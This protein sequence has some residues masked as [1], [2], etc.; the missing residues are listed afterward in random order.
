MEAGRRRG[1]RGH[2]AREGLGGQLSPNRVSR[3]RRLAAG[4]AMLRLGASNAGARL[5]QDL[6][7]QQRPSGPNDAATGE[8]EA[9]PPLPAIDVVKQEVCR[10]LADGYRLCL[11]PSPTPRLPGGLIPFEGSTGPLPYNPSSPP[12]NKRGLDLVGAV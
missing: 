11:Y 2:R 1:G 4:W 3:L 6:W 9:L 8:A 10:P 12:E 5:L 7:T